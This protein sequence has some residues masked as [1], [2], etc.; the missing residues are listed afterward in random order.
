MM[1]AQL[2]SSQFPQSWSRAGG[3]HSTFVHFYEGGNP[4]A[5]IL[6]PIIIH[7][8]GA[9]NVLVTNS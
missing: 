1:N 7:R 6:R 3:L 4:I 5:F 9:L 2:A 8:N